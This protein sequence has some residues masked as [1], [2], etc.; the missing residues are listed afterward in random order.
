MIYNGYGQF[1]ITST[2][3]ARCQSY[4]ICA[5]GTTDAGIRAAGHGD[6]AGADHLH[7]ADRTQQLD[8]ALDLVLGAGDLH[9][10]GIGS[11]I[12]NAGT[13]NIHEVIDFGAPL[14]ADL[15]FDQCQV[16][17]HRRLMGDV[18]HVD[19]I[20]ELVQI[21]LDLVRVH[22]AVGTIDHNGHARD[23]GV[24]RPPHRQRFN[25]EVTTAEQGSHPVENTGFIFNQGDKGILHEQT[26]YH[27]S[28]RMGRRII[29]CR[30]APVG[31]IG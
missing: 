2:G 13:E 25:I 22:V 30:A 23:I 1:A 28:T 14:G 21:G 3:S 24:F 8:H 11:H 19:H 5:R 12:H 4:T 7:D 31:T 20:D 15:D 29:S 18:L 9:D 10:H 6:L 26:P 27:S 16:A 17:G